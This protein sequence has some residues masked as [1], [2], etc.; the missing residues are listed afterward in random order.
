M[1]QIIFI[2][3]RSCIS[4]AALCRRRNP[5]GRH[6]MVG[7]YLCSYSQLGFFLKADLEEVMDVA[8]NPLVC[9]FADFLTAVQMFQDIRNFAHLKATMLYTDITPTITPYVRAREIY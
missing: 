3:F 1:M 8:M 2:M 4:A 7:Y 9:T 6:G 5:C